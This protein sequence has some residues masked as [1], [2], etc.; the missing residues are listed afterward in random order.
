MYVI[1]THVLGGECH[2]RHQ[3]SGLSVANFLTHP[4]HIGRCVSI[5]PL[6]TL[7]SNIKGQR[8]VDRSDRI[9]GLA[10]IDSPMV[11]RGDVDGEGLGPRSGRL[12]DP[13][14]FDGDGGRGMEVQSRTTI[15]P[16]SGLPSDPVRD[17]DVG[18]SGIQFL[19]VNF[20]CFVSAS[21]EF[22]CSIY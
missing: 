13:V 18:L 6:E 22:K 1:P 15:S 14:P 17:R 10:H 11:G 19:A 7:T 12:R 3:P 8:S 20:V 21:Y 5:S 16:T 4:P 2:C 9:L